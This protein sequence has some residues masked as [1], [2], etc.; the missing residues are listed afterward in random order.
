M[1]RVTTGPLAWLTGLVLAL[2]LIH[3]V[4]SALAL[5]H[6]SEDL[7]WFA[8]SGLAILTAGL[9]NVAMIRT[10]SVDRVQK[11]VWVSANMA[12]A[13]FFGAAWTLLPQPQVVVGGIAFALLAIGAATRPSGAVAA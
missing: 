1:G 13:L 3:L 9:L 7:L 8:G 4:L 5:Q 2:G 12:T 6:W 10:A 11:A